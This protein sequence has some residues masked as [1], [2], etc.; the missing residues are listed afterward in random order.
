ME[1]DMNRELSQIGSNEML[2]KIFGFGIS[3]YAIA[4]LAQ[5]LQSYSLV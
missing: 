4:L 5:V 1:G 2:G 3:L